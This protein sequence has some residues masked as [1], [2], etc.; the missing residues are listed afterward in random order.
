MAQ[1]W[2]YYYDL[3]RGPHGSAVVGASAGAIVV[4]AVL[5]AGLIFEPLLLPDFALALCFALGLLCLIV[6]VLARMR[7]K[8]NDVQYAIAFNHGLG[9]AGYALDDIFTEGA[10]ANP[11]LQLFNFKVLRLCRPKQILELGSGQT[12]KVL[13]WYARANSEAYV[14]TLEQDE[15]WVNR[16]KPQVAHDYRHVDL[17]TQEFT[18]RGTNLRLTAPWY[19]DVP[20][21]ESQRFDYVLVDGPDYG[22]RGTEHIDYSRGGILKWMPSILAESFVIVFDDA[23]RYGEIMT[24]G[25]LKSLLRACAVRFVSFAI[26]GM[27]TQVVLC[28]PD[29]AYL[30]SV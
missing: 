19:R 16:L 17:E 20:E 27:K 14:L 12:T 1:L 18:C 4:A 29:K 7:A 26:H 2:K 11:S 8:L 6:V 3:K 24:I 15:A 30:Q 10:A 25:A 28:S 9:R 22:K 5:L 23:E 13:S 21:L